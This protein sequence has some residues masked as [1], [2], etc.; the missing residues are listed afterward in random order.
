[1]KLLFGLNNIH[2]SYGAQVILDNATLS[3]YEGHKIGVIGRNG[4]GKSTLCKIIAGHETHDSG[5]VS[6]S[7]AFRF[8]YLEQHDPWRLDETVIDFLVRHTKKEPWQCGKIAASFQL[9]NELLRTTIGELPGG[10]R[11]RVKLAAMLLEEPNFLILDEP[12]NYLDLKTLILLEE[13]LKDYK[14]GFLIE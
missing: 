12:S 14:G 5:K 8:G 13:F 10:Y 1:M 9:K 7:A 3:V 4:A 6:K 11:T 2:K